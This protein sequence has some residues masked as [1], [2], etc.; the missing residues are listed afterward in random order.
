MLCS[1]RGRVH[2]RMSAYASTRILRVIRMKTPQKAGFRFAQQASPLRLIIRCRLLKT[3]PI[4]R[5]NYKIYPSKDAF[6]LE[7]YRGLVFLK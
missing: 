6:S 1:R 3:V 4:H 5:D 7:I 2:P